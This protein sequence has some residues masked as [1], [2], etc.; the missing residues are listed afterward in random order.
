MAPLLGEGSRVR[1]FISAAV[2]AM[3]VDTVPPAAGKPKIGAPSLMLFIDPFLQ[4][5]FLA[6]RA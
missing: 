3:P 6:G 2:A 4:V 1:E 5:S